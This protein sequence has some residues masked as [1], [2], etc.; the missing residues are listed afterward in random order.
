MII[1][2]TC[3]TCEKQ[4]TYDTKIYGRPRKFCSRPCAGNSRAKGIEERTCPQ[5]KKTFSCKSYKNNKYCGPSCA[6]IGTSVNQKKQY[7]VGVCAGCGNEFEKRRTGINEK[8]CS[9]KCS[10]AADKSAHRRLPRLQKTCLYCGKEFS[11]A[12]YHNTECCSRLCSN[13]QTAKTQVGE[14]HPL[15]KEKIEMTCEV[16]GKICQVKPSI[17]SRFRSCSRKCNAF[18]AQVIAP[19]FSSIEI[20]ML[21]ALRDKNLA[22]Y[23]QFPIAPYIT[24][25]AFPAQMLVVECDGDYWHASPQ[26]RAKDHAKD[27][28]LTKL[29]WRVLRL[30]ESEI[31]ASSTDCADRIIS[32]L[33]T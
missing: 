11:C 23:H 8:Y 13:R 27:K 2:K 22:P 19:R 30:K 17:V 4:F 18:L 15:H 33:R 24:D 25:I 3:P 28:F 14:N 26:Q 6:R 21:K 16:C 5:C 29:G 32:L 31:K 20:A 1:E 10:D 12:P 9:R 7:P